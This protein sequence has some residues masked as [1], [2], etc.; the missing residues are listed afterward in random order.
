MTPKDSTPMA[1]LERAYALQESGYD[2]LP[3]Y[4]LLGARWLENLP[5]RAS[6]RQLIR[7]QIIRRGETPGFYRL[8]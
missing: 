1:L 8:A 3:A 7:A 5:L 6:L 4:R 2:D